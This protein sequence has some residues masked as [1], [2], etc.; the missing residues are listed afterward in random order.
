MKKLF[1]KD[2]W[3][4]QDIEILVGQILRIGVISASI[5]VIIGGIVYL[6]AHGQ[7]LVP[8]YQHF[9]G[10]GEVNTTIS[11]ILQGVGKFQ[12]PQIIQF[13]VVILIATPVLRI[14]CSLFGFIL[15]RD[16]LYIIITCIVLA[17]ITFSI[18]GGVKG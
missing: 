2:Y 11:G 13:G 16:R 1:S 17:I 10:E 14:I 5:V 18:L 6:I 15:E 12:A 3:A 8:D 9:V 4:D 7:Q